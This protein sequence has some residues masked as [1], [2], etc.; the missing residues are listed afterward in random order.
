VTT[1]A[2]TRLRE[3]EVQALDA[4]RLEPLIGPERMARYETIAEATQSAMAG[5]I[6][7]NLN[8]T[9]AGGGVAE[10]LQT[11]LAYGRGAGLDV[12]WLV[13]DG[14]PAFFEITKRIHNGLY[15]S[16]G[17]GGDLGDRER[18]HYEAVAERNVEELLAL[19][20]PS[21][22]VL[23]HDPQ[24]AGM[25]PALLRAGA[26]VVWRCH[27]GAD[28]PNEW[29]ERSWSFLR[30]YLE[31]VD[32]FVF[33]RRAFAPAWADTARTHVIPP[34]IDP[35]SAKN[36]PISHRNV[37]LILGYVGL[38]AGDGELPAVPFTRRDGSPGRINRRVDVLQTGPPPS[39]DA[40]LVV[41]VSRWD[42]MKDMP[43]VMA[44]FA[45]HVDRS[46][47]AHL[48]LAG[49]AVTG[50]A[51]D[52]EAAEV[53][54]ECMALWRE[55]PHAARSRVHLA[56]TPMSDPDEAAAIVNALQRHASVVV[57]KSI[58][59]GFGLTVAEAMWKARPIVA[60]AVGGIVDQVSSGEHGLLVDDPLDL[61][62]FGR[63]VDRLLRN[64]GEADRLG[65][66]ARE[67]AREE[68]LGDR[69]LAQYGRVL[70]RLA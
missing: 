14:D 69:H 4:A 54:G 3:V 12:R 70:E 67:R 53:L 23:V 41:Q 60:S 44:G 17:D 30:P 28:A 20:R 62:T 7:F 26:K 57:Q 55:L 32:A 15:G 36:E 19:V 9:A 22:V 51:D 66:N 59:E 65:T 37:K 16:D 18:R 43:G 5:R 8:S 35:F 11:L 50:V 42:R 46:L 10:M 61:P 45:E 34:S 39:P 13:V 31:E 38:L 63:L 21:D 1:A 58:A 33:S 68:F 49:P 27:V 64:R 6:V 40:P 24:P 25:V 2:P 48:L 52:P 47:G 56:C 29:T